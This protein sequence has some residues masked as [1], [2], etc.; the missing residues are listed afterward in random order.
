[1]KSCGVSKDEQK[2]D[3]DWSEWTDIEASLL[4]R[5]DWTAQAITGFPSETEKH[6]DQHGIR[7]IRFRKLFQPPQLFSSA[8]LYITAMGL[9]EAFLN[10]NRIGDGYLTPGWTAY[11]SRIQYQVYDVTSLLEPGGV[12]VLS[13][14]VAEGWYAGRLAWGAGARHR[15]T[16]EAIRLAKAQGAGQYHDAARQ[17]A[18]LGLHP[19]RAR[20]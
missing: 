4:D 16:T 12:N 2:I 14:E 20:L 19:S 11:Q 5:G 7:P 18:D 9:Y 3:T 10:G 1:M 15:V 6:D 17:R 8:R 13:A